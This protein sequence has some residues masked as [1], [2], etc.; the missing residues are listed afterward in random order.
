[1]KLIIDGKSLTLDRIER[2]IKENQKV[3]LSSASKK[4]IAKARRLIDK[5]VNSGEAIYGVTT[6]FGEFSNVKISQE[7]TEALQRNLIL[8]HSA[9]VGFNIPPLIVKI[10]MLLR[11]NALARGNSGIRIETLNLLLEMINNNIIPVIPSQGSVG[12]SGD[13]APL[14]HL[15]LAMIG[16]GEVQ[17]TKNVLDEKSSDT[18]KTSAKIA[19]KKLF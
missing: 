10:M 5:W 11:A 7:E 18:K 9:G 19:L 14:S 13:L 3:V 12:S 16:E 1:M 4:R 2:F 17:I 15:V 8:S 6:G